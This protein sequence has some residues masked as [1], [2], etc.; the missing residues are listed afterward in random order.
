MIEEK[1]LE[2]GFLDKD[3]IIKENQI[4]TK[5]KDIFVFIYKIN[6]LAFKLIDETI[7]QSDNVK[8]AV[9]LFFNEIHISFQS[10]IILLKKGLSN[11]ADI[12]LRGIYEK[13][14]KM[15]ALIRKRRHFKLLIEDT[16]YYAK[17][18]IEDNID[19]PLLNDKYKDEKELESLKVKYTSID[20]WAKHAGLYDRYIFDYS[21]LSSNAHG[22]YSIVQQ[23]LIKKED[24]F[25]LN[26][27]FK[28]DDFPQDTFRMIGIYMKSIEKYIEYFNIEKYQEKYKELETE[29]EEIFKKYISSSDKE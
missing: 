22:D 3:I 25:L 23:S 1:A 4:E 19:N 6:D 18:I 10:C 12:V 11:D 5:Y 8:I 21:F 29:A 2:N 17:K 28:Y 26:S 20:L 15:F 13:V 16:K 14:F 24:G 27:G 9:L 7:N